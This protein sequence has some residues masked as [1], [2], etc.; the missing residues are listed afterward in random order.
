MGVRERPPARQ[1]SFQRTRRG[2]PRGKALTGAEFAHSLPIRAA[3]Y[4][5]RKELQDLDFWNSGILE[6]VGKVKDGDKDT[7]IQRVSQTDL[8]S[9]VPR[10]KISEKGI[11]AWLSG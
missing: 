7:L 5:A 11:P 3:R 10:F 9:Q 4:A 2:P 1:L 6:S 8:I